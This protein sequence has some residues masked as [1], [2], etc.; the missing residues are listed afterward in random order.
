MWPRTTLFSPG[1]Y[2]LSCSVQLVGRVRR[3][4]VGRVGG[5]EFRRLGVRRVATDWF[6]AVL[7]P[8]EAFP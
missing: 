8:V 1:A 7:G 6:P 2:F 4:R 5:L 3:V